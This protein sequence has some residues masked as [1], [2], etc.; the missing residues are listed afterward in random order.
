MKRKKNRALNGG[1]KKKK[2]LKKKEKLGERESVRSI[3][4]KDKD[5]EAGVSWCDQHGW[6]GVEIMSER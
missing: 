2:P 5:A 4:P 3:L 6:T 1:K